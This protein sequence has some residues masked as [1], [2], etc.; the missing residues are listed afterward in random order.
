MNLI[1]QYA[2]RNDDSPVFKASVQL[3]Q[4]Q[5]R[6]MLCSQVEDRGIE[7]SFNDG[8]EMKLRCRYVGG[9]PNDMAG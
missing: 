9:W 4:P 1:L 2:K 8:N 7:L 3:T 6:L 5:N